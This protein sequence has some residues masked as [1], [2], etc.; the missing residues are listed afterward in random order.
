VTLATDIRSAREAAGLTRQRVA[1]L[2][3]LS[4]TT[5]RNAE[6]GRSDPRNSTVEAIHAAIASLTPHSKTATPRAT[7]ARAARLK[8]G[9]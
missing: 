5:V 3:G 2:A 9:G 8:G 4:L 1:E 7:D 6:R